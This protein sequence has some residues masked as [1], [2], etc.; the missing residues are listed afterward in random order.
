MLID[1]VQII[2]VE[3]ALAYRDYVTYRVTLFTVIILFSALHLKLNV[4]K[5]D[6][7]LVTTS[8]LIRENNQLNSSE[9]LGCR[10]VRQVD[11]P[12][13]PTGNSLSWLSCKQ[14]QVVK[15]TRTT[16]KK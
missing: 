15:N 5:C 4:C 10:T 8:L 14:T 11:S 3:T 6:E 9:E 7:G 13:D 16:F 1:S 12:S 2:L